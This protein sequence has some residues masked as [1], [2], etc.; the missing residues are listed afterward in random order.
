MEAITS[1]ECLTRFIFQRSHFSPNK[2]RVKYAAF[3][4]P[5]GEISAYRI[6]GIEDTEIWDIGLLVVA[7]VSQREL[8]A[9]ADFL[10]SHAFDNNLSVLPDT[11]IH[12]RHA[13]VVNWPKKESERKLI[14]IKL[15]EQSELYIMHRD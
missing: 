6:S 3:M 9:R 15:A 2:N 5:N 10:A 7:P 4:P 8:R 14:A 13:N 1:E 11:R 12:P